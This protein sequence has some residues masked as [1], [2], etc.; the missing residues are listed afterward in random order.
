MLGM[1]ENRVYKQVARPK[2]K[3]VVG[4]KMLYKRKI[5][6]D[7]KVEKYKYRLVAQGFW[8][9]ERVHYTEKYSPTPATASI[10][11]LLAMAAAKDGE[12]R[13]FDAEQAFLKAD[14]DKE[15]YI[16]IP[17]EFQEFPGAVGRLNKAIYGLVQAGRC[18]NNKSCDDIT[19]IGFEQVKADLYVF[20]KVVDGQ[21]E[22]VVVVHVDDILAHV[23]GQA[24]MDR[25]AAELGQKFKMKEMG[26]AGYYMGCHIT[27]NRKAHEL[28][29]D[30][31][32]YVESMVKRFDVKKATKIPAASGVSNALKGGRMA[33]PRGEGRNEEVPVPGGGGGAY[34][35]G[36]DDTAGHC[37]RRTRCGQVLRKPWDGA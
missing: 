23:K 11:M 35:D 14:T 30:Q 20:R 2:D 17:E 25:F 26:D 33:E 21:A 37:V 1:V 8:Q 4:T 31:D 22:M 5:G 9:A 36:D 3:L 28:K 27:R 12:L 6:K 15:I 29:L 24:T 32:L 34:V 10:W 13:H 18:W 16:E 19:A 7:G